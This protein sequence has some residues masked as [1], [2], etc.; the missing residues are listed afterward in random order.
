MFKL[1]RCDLCGECLE[2]CYHLSFDKSNG[3]AEIVK[4]IENEKVDWLYDCVTCMACNEYCPTGARPFDLILSRLEKE[5]NFTDPHLLAEMKDR[6]SA[7]S[8]PKPVELKEKVI[9]LCVMSGSA[10][11]AFQGQL[12]ESAAILKGLPYF[13]NVLF[14]HMGNETL[15]RDRIEPL[16][17]NLAK[18]GAK[19]IVFVHEDCY[20]ML[21]NIAKE[22]GVALPFKPVHLFEYLR[23][24]LLQHQDQI[25]KLN[26]RIAYQRPCASRYTPPEVERILNEVFELIGVERVI[27]QY[28]GIHAL[29]CGNETGGPNKKLFPRG[30]NFEP[31]RDKNIWNAKNA[32]AEA[33]V[34]LCPMCFKNLHEKARASGM[35]NYMVTD[36]CRLALGEELPKDKPE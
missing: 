14:A 34:Y 23:E 2:S 30:E 28:D 6:F 25:N 13:C 24:Y 1:E 8:E 35:K 7:K 21:N 4:L 18:S 3:S 17:N 15:M 19:E 20:A 10:P 11:W 27:R 36:L 33:M 16:V 22:Y 9:S 29:C 5:G 26:L 32:G 31:F 12:F